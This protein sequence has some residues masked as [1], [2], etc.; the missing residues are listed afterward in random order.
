[1]E[2]LERNNREYYTIDILHVLHSLWKR[3]WIIVLS[4]ILVGAIGFS[5]ATF[6]ITP[7]YSSYIKL[8]VSNSSI[9]IGN[10]NFSISSSELTAAQSL[11]KTYGDILD[12]RST[13]TRI[14]K[15]AKLS[16]NWKELSGMISCVPSNDTEVM[17]VTVI[18][19]DPNEASLI[20]NTIAEVLPK[21]ISEII[22]GASVGVVDTAI[23][24]FQKVGPS[25]TKYTLVG[26]VLGAFLSAIIIMIFAL[27]DDTIRDE[28]YILAAY[29]YPILGKVPNL[30]EIGSKS[31]SYYSRK[32][33]GN[34]S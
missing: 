31:Y 19:E 17:R 16:Y 1:M 2:K 6:L 10:S 23:P 34:E 27:M 18:S 25:V 11:V 12:S 32:H 21:R 29:D 30:M 22:D 24:D 7:T 15:K 3:M 9:Q 28:E 5:I 13:L 8:Y 14:I 20:A 26:F 4:G 33:H